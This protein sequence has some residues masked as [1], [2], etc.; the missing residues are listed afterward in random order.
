MPYLKVTENYEKIG[1]KKN[2]FVNLKEGEIVVAEEYN[3]KIP[4]TN[5]SSL[6]LNK[7][8][9]VPTNII[10]PVMMSDADA[11]KMI[12]K[13]VTMRRELEAFHKKQEYLNEKPQ[14]AT[15][16]TATAVDADTEQDEGEDDAA[17]GGDDAYARRARDN[18]RAWLMKNEMAGGKKKKN[19]TEQTREISP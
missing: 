17:D 15:P 13:Q 4:Y 11:T 9:L 8:F 10:K 6:I 7:K 2:G 12:D 18:V 3:P 5:I 16:V 14:F 1:G 19:E